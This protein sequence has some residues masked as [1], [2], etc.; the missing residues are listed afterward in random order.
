MR[1][2]HVIPFLWS[3]AGNVVT[4]LCETQ[5]SG[6]QVG[7]VT[8]GKSK[9]FD[10]WTEYRK[11]LKSAG[12]EHFNIDFFDRDPAVFW[13]STDAF[14]KLAATWKA[15][16]IHCHSGVPACAAAMCKLDFI[17]QIHSWGVG[18]PEWMNAMDLRGF[19]SAKRVLCGSL[20]YQKIL[21]EGGVEPS[22][23]RYLPWGLNLKDIYRRTDHP[24]A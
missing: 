4:R 3:G 6:N 21:I 10:D 17:G 2:L 24:G 8:S 13:R 5:A 12:V 11:R 7:I 22:R 9:G 1:I 20:A 15:D 14:E 19:R 18:R 16:I 23:I